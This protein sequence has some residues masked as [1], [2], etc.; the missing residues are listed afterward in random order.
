MVL[1]IS[2]FISRRLPTTTT[3]SDGP[4]YN[5][6]PIVASGSRISDYRGSYRVLWNRLKKSPELLA[7]IGVPITDI[8]GDR[9]IWLDVD[10][11]PLGPTNKRKAEKFWRDNRVK[12]ICKSW[13]YDGFLTGDGFMWKGKPNKR[14]VTRAMKEVCDSYGINLSNLQTKEMQ[15]II[16]KTIDEVSAQPKKIDY[17]AASTV[18]VEHSLTEILRYVQNAAGAKVVFSPEE[19]IHFRYLTVNGEVEGFAPAEALIAEI[20]L[21]LLVKEN[22]VAYMK[23]GGSPDKVFILPKE[24]A[25][26]PNHKY[27]IQTLQKY[28]SVENRHGNLVF[29]GEL[30]IEDL[31]GSPK[32]LEYKDLALYITSIVAY[33]YHIPISRLPFLIGSAANKGDAGGLSEAGYWNMI[34]DLQDTVEDLLNS[35][36]FEPMGWHIRF[37]RKY[38]QDEV[39]EAQTASMNADTVIKIQNIMAKCGKQIK[40][41]KVA[42]MLK[43]PDE[44][45]EDWMPSPQE[46]M[47]M[48][49]EDEAMKMRNQ[50][51]LPNRQ[52][53][54]ESDNQKKADV[55]RNSANQKGSASASV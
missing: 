43:I 7:T 48:Q 31:Q 50:N 21:L 8:L 14:E 22:M 17:V 1:Q 35:Q 30:N 46:E 42:E 37:Q 4:L 25:K 28:K 53:K 3:S 11:K 6:V 29:T 47:N 55:K 38:K 45:L 44:D 39:R 5:A 33:A 23:N 24:L 19:I 13:L 20:I 36:L 32:D 41:E 12:E 26:S 16:T 49:R 54:P 52:T 51:M 9:P 2:Q 34:S 10:D 40:A 18:T 27:L 15:R